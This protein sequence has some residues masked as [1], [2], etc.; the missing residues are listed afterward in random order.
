M[1]A[2]ITATAAFAL[3]SAC[4]SPGDCLGGAA[5]ATQGSDGAAALFVLPVA[6]VAAG[7]CAGITAAVNDAAAADTADKPPE[8]TRVAAPAPAHESAR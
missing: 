2:T 7:V 8:D 4:A 5:E 3:L 1:Q 6:L